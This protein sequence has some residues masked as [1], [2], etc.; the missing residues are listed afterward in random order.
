MLVERII[1]VGFSSAVLATMATGVWSRVCKGCINS[2]LPVQPCTRWLPAKTLGSH[3]DLVVRDKVTITT[4]LADN[5]VVMVSLAG[6]LS[7][8]LKTQK[9]GPLKILQSDI[10]KKIRF[11]CVMKCP[12][13]HWTAVHTDLSLLPGIPYAARAMAMRNTLCLVWTQ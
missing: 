3:L 10:D 9:F 4:W 8:D 12:V 1:G 5:M 6:Y 13:T 2:A 7:F 11:I